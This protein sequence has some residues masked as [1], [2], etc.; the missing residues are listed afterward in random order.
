VDV[1]VVGTAVG[2]PMNQATGRHGRRR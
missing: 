2:Q 1:V